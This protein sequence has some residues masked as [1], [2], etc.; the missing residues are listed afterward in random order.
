M[1]SINSTSSSQSCYGLACICTNTASDV[2]FG[3]SEVK[4]SSVINLLLR[5]SHDGQR[6][7]LDDE[8]VVSTSSK[9]Y[10]TRIVTRTNNLDTVSSSINNFIGCNYITTYKILN[11]KVG[12]LNQ[13]NLSGCVSSSFVA[14]MV[15]SNRIGRLLNGSRI[16]KLLVSS[17][18][19]S[20]S[21]S[22]IRCRTRNRLR[23]NHHIT[24]S[25]HHLEVIVI[26]WGYA[27]ECDRIC[28]CILVSA[29][30]IA[31]VCSER[32]IVI[33]VGNCVSCPCNSNV[34]LV[35]LQCIITSSQIKLR[36][37]TCRSYIDSQS[38]LLHGESTI[39]STCINALTHYLCVISLAY[40]KE[41]SGNSRTCAVILLKET[42]KIIVI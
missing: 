26:L 7:L 39:G 17:R 38:C 9:V 5:E 3:S 35:S 6:S 4:S 8:L 33:L 11:G 20:G 41:I 12:A 29:I 37:I 34:T 30:A 15:P 22:I 25:I 40:L 42:C 1:S 10:G 28:T 14:I 23:L 13:G 19:I 31:I 24:S 21:R 27:C 18:L 16:S 32:Y 36:E 2:K